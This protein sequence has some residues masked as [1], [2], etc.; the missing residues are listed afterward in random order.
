MFKNMGRFTS[1]IEENYSNYTRFG[2]LYAIGV[3]TCSSRGPQRPRA[4]QLSCASKKNDFYNKDIPIPIVGKLGLIR[5]TKRPADLLS[6]S[7]RKSGEKAVLSIVSWRSSFCRNVESY[8]N[9]LCLSPW[10]LC[11]GQLGS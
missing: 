3:A 1:F 9:L 4:L 2:F 11:F 6:F 7:Q 5:K 8:G 10:K